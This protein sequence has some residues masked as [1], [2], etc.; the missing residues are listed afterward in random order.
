MNKP[1]R[2]TVLTGLIVVAVMSLFP[3]WRDMERGTSAGY[4]LI[5]FAPGV[6][7]V[8]DISRLVV[9]LLLVAAVCAAVCL[10][11]KKSDS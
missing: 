6:G 10:L 5:F 7:D 3:P 11:L 9:Q 4:Y 2:D 1:Q 8:V